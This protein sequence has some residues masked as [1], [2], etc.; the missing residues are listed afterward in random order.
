[1][2]AAHIIGQSS[3]TLWGLT[4]HARLARQLA[5]IEGVE[6]SSKA[7]GSLA[8]NALLIR[9]DYLFEPRTLKGLLQRGGVLMDG[10]VA[11][12]AAVEAS[13]VEVAQA[14]LRGEATPA[15]DGL[16]RLGADDL[17]AFEGDLRL[18]T[19]PLLERITPSRA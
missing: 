9:A 3:L 15:A 4:S 14:L 11:A 7:P 16:S 5:R 2:T 18:A 19:P 13:Q 12:A 1:M 6:L 17:A 10:D 8:G